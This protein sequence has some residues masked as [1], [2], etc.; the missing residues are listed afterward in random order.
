MRNILKEAYGDVDTSGYICIGEVPYYPWGSDREKV[1]IMVSPQKQ[2]KW[3]EEVYDIRY[4]QEP[5]GTGAQVSDLPVYAKRKAVIYDEYQNT[6]FGELFLGKRKSD[7]EIKQKH[8]NFVSKLFKVGND[9][10]IHHNSSYKITDGVVKKG[11]QNGWSNNTDIGIYFWG[12]RISGK[13]P[14]NIGEYSYYCVIPMNELYDFE[15]NVERLSLDI[16]LRKYKYAGQ[17]WRNS[18]AIV[19][20]TLRETPIWAILS[21]SDGKWYDKNW[22]EIEKPF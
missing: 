3:G 17:F 18:D 21:K 11:N 2:L 5:D 6:E 19:V 13:D 4:T 9:V 7:D 14:S 16:I 10:I 8:Q 22:N 12:S 20:S 15:T 1:Y